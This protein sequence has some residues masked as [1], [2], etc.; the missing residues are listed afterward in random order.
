MMCRGEQPLYIWTV[1]VLGLP[2]IKWSKVFKLLG[3]TIY[4]HTNIIRKDD[5]C[6]K[7]ILNVPNVANKIFTS[8]TREK[9]SD[10][11][12]TNGAFDFYGVLLALITN[13]LIT[14]I[15]FFVLLRKLLGYFKL[16]LW[17][18]LSGTSIWWI[19]P[20]GS[21]LLSSLVHWNFENARSSQDSNSGITT[22]CQMFNTLKW[23][24]GFRVKFIR[25][26]VSVSR[27]SGPT[28]KQMVTGSRPG[29]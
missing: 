20:M 15:K 9:C 14:F 21:S 5:W 10:L 7:S 3:R 27:L 4:K 11:F 29:H 13:V 16:L 24:P 1:V 26:D 28:P 18:V 22:N 25:A 6:R 19:A 2:Y 17:N 12:K 23:S 8:V